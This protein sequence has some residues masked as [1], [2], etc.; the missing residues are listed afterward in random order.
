L[1]LYRLTFLRDGGIMQPTVKDLM[2][3]LHEYATVSEDATLFEAVIA[4][5]KAQ[6][7]FDQNRYR[8]RAVL[9]LDKN[10]KVIGK[11]SQ[12]DILRA[13]EPKYGDMGD[14]IPLT[15]FGYSSKFMSSL[16]EKFK[17]W[18]TPIY[19]TCRKSMNVKVTSFMYVPTE[20]EYVEE[21]STITEAIHH[22]VMG[23]HQSLLVTKE[24]KIVGILRLTDV[25]RE[26]TQVVKDCN[27]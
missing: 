18:D 25:F 12:L 9:I 8:H 13:L 11:V 22:L 27:T 23:H 3:P 24:K 15:R 2:V 19:E 6:S 17:L 10:G 5:E 7:E 26:I 21:E 4:L 20:E 1:G 16:L 14:H